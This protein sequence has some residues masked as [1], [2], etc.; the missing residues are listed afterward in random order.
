MGNVISDTLTLKDKMYPDISPSILN[1]TNKIEIRFFELPSFKLTNYTIFSYNETWNATH[2][3]QSNK[4]TWLSKKL[5]VNSNDSLFYKLAVNNIFSLPNQD[6]LMCSA[7][8]YD[9]ETNEIYASGLQVLDGTTYFIEFKVGNYYRRYRY[10]DPEHYADF[11]SHVN[12]LR[13]FATIVQLFKNWI[14]K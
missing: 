12:E 5:E 8:E 4:T 1:S 2:Y 9:P 7:G 14:E 13:N 6:S 11:F 10:H 3:Y